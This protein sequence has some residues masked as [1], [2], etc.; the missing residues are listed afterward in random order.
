MAEFTAA[1]LMEAW[2]LSSPAAAHD[3]LGALLAAGEDGVAVADDT[4][5][6]RNRRLLALHRD[7]VGGALEAR[8]TCADCAANSEFMVPADGILATPAPNPDARARLEDG[9]T[10]LTFRL[11]RMSD[12]TAMRG[13]TA[14]GDPRRAVVARCACQAGPIPDDA[15]HRL[16]ALFDALDPAANIVVAIACSGCARPIAASVDLADFVARDLDRTVEALFHE[17]DRLARAYGWSEAAILAL[18]PGR[19]RRYVAM[20]DAVGARPALMGRR[21]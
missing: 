21:A 9:D 17:V 4:L 2:D 15:T 7:L 8:V 13:E 11:P 6:A 19:R 16:E 3:R 5:G 10:V 1:V 20:V 12:L 14:K 18:P